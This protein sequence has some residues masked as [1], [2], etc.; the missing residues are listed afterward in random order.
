MIFGD[1]NDWK[2]KDHYLFKYYKKVEISNI[3]YI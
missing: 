2:E 1:K 3:C